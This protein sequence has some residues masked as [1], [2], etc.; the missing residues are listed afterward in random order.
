MESFAQLPAADLRELYTQP[1][2]S[3][4]DAGRP[5]R[6]WRNPPV[7]PAGGDYAADDA[8]RYV[9]ALERVSAR[10]LGSAIYADALHEHVRGQPLRL[11]PIGHLAPEGAGASRCAAYVTGASWALGGAT[12][13]RQV[14]RQHRPPPPAAG[15]GFSC[16]VRP[17]RDLG[18][19]ALKDRE[20]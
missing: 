14:W 10:Y 3:E 12:A 7:S 16:Y 1:E 13:M 4:L 11:D 2:E 8:R 5:A 17:E 15:E 9:G 20:R 19:D 18:D 6:C